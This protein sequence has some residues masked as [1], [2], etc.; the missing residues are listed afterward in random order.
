K[1]LRRLTPQRVGTD[2]QGGTSLTPKAESQVISVL[3]SRGGVGCT[4]VAVNLG[5][6]LAQDPACAIALV[7]LDLA[8]GDADVALDLMADY[9]LADVALNI[10]RL[11]LQ[12]LN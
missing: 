6:T 12:F 3:G 5:A 8:L 2:S 7:D 1:A 11:D 4:S 10:E 9:T